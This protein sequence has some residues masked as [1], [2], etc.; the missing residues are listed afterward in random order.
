KPRQ[1]GTSQLHQVVVAAAAE[2]IG[3]E[4]VHTGASGILNAIWI[5]SSAN[6]ASSS[7][8]I[9]AGHGCSSPFAAISNRLTLATLS[10]FGTSRSASATSSS[11]GLDPSG[12][13]SCALPPSSVSKT[14][15]SAFW[16]SRATAPAMS[17]DR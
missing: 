17:R 14:V 10:R 4:L 15:F 6:M 7:A 8:L 16:T 9:V 5:P 2:E 12:H 13:P 11:L 1:L 3:R